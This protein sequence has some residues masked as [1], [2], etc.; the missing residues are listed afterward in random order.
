MKEIMHVSDVHMHW[1]ALHYSVRVAMNECLYLLQQ[2]L[3]SQR[4]KVRLDPRDKCQSS[5]NHSQ[6]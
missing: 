3:P 2:S 6:K 4:S 5:L 1:T